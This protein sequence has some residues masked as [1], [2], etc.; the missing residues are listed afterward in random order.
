M[1]QF[2]QEIMPAVLQVL[3]TIILGLIGLAVP[4]IKQYFDE[5]GILQKLEQYDYLADIAVRAVE[6]IYWNEDGEVKKVKAKEFILESLD[7]LGLD[8][9]PQQLDMFIESAVKRGKEEWNQEVVVIE[10]PKA[11][12]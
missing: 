3:S 5:K 6:Q 1:E 8:I 10:E 9:T 4:K 12:E 2:V 7:K 11:G